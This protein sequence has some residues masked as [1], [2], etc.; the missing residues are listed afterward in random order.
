MFNLKPSCFKFS[1]VNLGLVYDYNPCLNISEEADE[2]NM[3]CSDSVHYSLPIVPVY[4]PLHPFIRFSKISF[5]Y[6][7]LSLPKRFY[8]LFFKFFIQFIEFSFKVGLLDI[9]VGNPTGNFRDSSNTKS[10]CCQSSSCSWI[11]STSNGESGGYGNS[12]V[13]YSFRYMAKQYCSVAK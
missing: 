8:M 3:W 5:F 1:W 4:A 12:S 2:W 13:W 11:S 7:N 6:V 9:G 10:H